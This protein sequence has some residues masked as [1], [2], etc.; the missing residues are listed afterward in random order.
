L[1]PIEVIKLTNVERAKYGVDGLSR[2]VKLDQAAT[3]KLQDMFDR[4]YFDHVS[5]D[6]KGPG[7]LAT[8]AGYSYVV[9][10]E[11]LAMGTFES[12]A[13]LVEAWMKSQGHRENI[14]NDRFTEIGVAVGHGTYNGERIWIAVQEFGKPSSECPAIDIALRDHIEKDKVAVTNMQN[15]INRRKTELETMKHDTPEESLAYNNKI[16]AYN[17]LVS[18]YNTEVANLKKQ[19]D[20]Y[21]QGIRDFNACA[22]D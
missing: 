5:P 8:R 4:Q 10:G 13:A 18:K 12:D 7:Y 22:Q 17:D 21:N 6:G 9:V 2:N 16:Q 3:A 14:L 11:N 20:T 1:S 19:I 15:E